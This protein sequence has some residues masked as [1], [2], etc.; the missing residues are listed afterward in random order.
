MQEKRVLPG[1]GATASAI[2]TYTDCMWMQR[3]GT[4]E[5]RKIKVNDNENENENENE[6]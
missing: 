3:I 6:S 4:S 5:K 2:D 1:A